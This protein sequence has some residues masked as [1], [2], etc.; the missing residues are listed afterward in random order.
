MRTLCRQ[1]K[2]Q[3]G[4]ILLLA[5]GLGMLG[6]GP[7]PAQPAP[8]A[9]AA[10]SPGP[11]PCTP[12]VSTQA[13]GLQQALALAL[14][15]DPRTQQSW[16]QWQ[17][18]TA[19]LQ[20]QRAQARPAVTASV[21]AGT[22]WQR[23]RER[24]DSS[25][26][27]YRSGVGAAALEL[28]WV[29]MDFGQQRASVEAAQLE[30]L[31]A[32]AAHDDTV[33]EVTLA[34]ARAF[35]ALAEAEA[36]VQVLVQEASFTDNLLMQHDRRGGG[37]APDRTER[38]GAR[39]APHQIKTAARGNAIRQAPASTRPLK[40]A[41]P[42]QLIVEA[43]EPES[44]A[45]SLLD[46]EL[47]RLQLR[48]DQSRA[49]LER[50][51]AQGSL[52]EARGELAVQ[53]GLPLQ[54][55]LALKLD[56]GAPD[57][58]PE[59]TAV[60]ALLDVIQRDHPALRAA[61]ARLGAAG[62]TLDLARRSTAP[63]ISLQHAQRIG[64]DVYRAGSRD[65]SLGLQLEVPLFAGELRQQREA[66]ARAQIEAARSEL[67]STERQ[68]AL[69]T[70][71]AWQAM[72]TQALALRQAQAYVQDAQALLAGELASYRADNSDLTDVLDAHGTVS[73]ATLARL[74]SLT[75]WRQARVR[76]AAALGRLHL[77][78]VSAPGRPR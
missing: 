61:R 72:Q 32:A 63:R 54:Q 7:A 20:L 16:A 46:A 39:P 36:T 65:V 21:E 48:A 10:G 28:S 38:S 69:Q 40:Q 67:R 18:R 47:E 73:Q 44:S 43:Q 59:D 30:A 27:V 45:E 71:Q 13:L 62:A 51:L 75:A 57:I 52:L 68:V 50:L 76:L 17:A 1:M 33:M 60:D 14:C 42:Q 19:E 9:F 15:N 6:S 26:T 3:H 66:L 5:V 77:A 2:R 23:L 25:S 78:A 49:T 4:W 55:T 8:G 22:A 37:D 53:L 29:L 35:F 74:S 41:R 34:T 24:T 11:A 58:G 70:W 56:E 31:A 64:R 12:E